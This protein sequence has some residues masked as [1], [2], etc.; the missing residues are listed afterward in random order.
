MSKWVGRGVR[1]LEQ[2]VTDVGYAYGANISLK[3]SR[4]V[5]DSE[6]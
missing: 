2:S 6:V 4:N 1:R 3:G 5:V